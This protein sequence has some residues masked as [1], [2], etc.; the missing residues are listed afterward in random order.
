[1]TEAAIDIAKE[2]VKYETSA[3]P[4]TNPAAMEELG[5]LGV[6]SPELTDKMAQG[7]RFRNV[8]AHTYG[9]IINQDFVYNALQNLGRYREFV[10][11]LRTYLD[12]IGA[13]ENHTGDQ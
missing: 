2:I 13:L 7:A 11:A 8:L 10:R 1:M 4:S 6:L 9:S 3:A 12:S 5:E